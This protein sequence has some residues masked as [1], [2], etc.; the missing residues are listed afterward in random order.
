MLIKYSHPSSRAHWRTALVF[1]ALWAASAETQAI[2]LSAADAARIGHKI[3]QNECNGTV[4]G[5]TSWNEGED[6]A[7]LGIGHFIWYPKGR[8]GPFEESF[9][10]FVAFAGKRGADLPAFLRAEPAAPCPWS[11]RAEFVRAQN[12]PE[13][14]SLRHF[15][16]GSVP[17]QTEFMVQRLETALGKMLEAA[18]QPQQR[19]TVRANFDRLAATAQGCYA[20][21]DYVNFKGEGVLETERY[22]GEGWGLLQVLETMAPGDSSPNRA[23]AHAAASV[24]RK[25]VANSPPARHESRW[26]PGWLNRVNSYTR[27]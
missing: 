24:L 20:L 9:P 4:A 13:M 8:R 2:A 21:I 12:S 19:T 3:W 25:R 18:Q 5:L 10:K 11:S 14:T 1:V 26:L 27:D 22:N 17:I 16:A 23:F 7:S 15:L 6:F